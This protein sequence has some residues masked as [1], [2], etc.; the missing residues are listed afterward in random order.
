[1]KRLLTLCAVSMLLVLLASPHALHAQ[2]ATPAMPATPAKPATKTEAK[3]KTT[4]VK[5]NLNTAS[6]EELMKLTGVDSATA[7]KIIAAR[8]YKSKKDLVSKKVLTQAEYERI[9][10]HI[11]VTSNTQAATKKPGR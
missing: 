9:H 1:M 6:K 10:G 2:S 7:D 4:V 8:P 11:K 3:P 5:Y